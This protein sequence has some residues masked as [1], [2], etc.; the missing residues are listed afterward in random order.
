MVRSKYLEA[1]LETHPDHCSAPDAAANMAMLQEAW[2]EY[3]KRTSMRRHPCQGYAD[4]G[5]GCSFA[6]SAEERSE[7]AEIM[8][9]ASRGVMNPKTLD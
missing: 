6:D 2:E 5:V 9:M 1:A 8:E 7:R 3:S 4:F